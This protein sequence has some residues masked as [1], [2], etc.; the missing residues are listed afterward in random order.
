MLGNWDVWG[1]HN[2]EK[3]CLREK[4]GQVTQGR[5]ISTELLKQLPI[6]NSARSLWVKIG[7]SGV[8]EL[9]E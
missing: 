4:K 2:L 8:D 5:F 1:R 6:P 3:N 9:N 7:F